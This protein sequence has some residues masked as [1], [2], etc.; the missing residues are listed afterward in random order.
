[1]IRS[2]L[3]DAVKDRLAIR[4]DGSG[5]SLDGLI[6]NTYVNTSINDA[7]NRLSIERDWWWLATTAS[8]TFSTTTGKASL[9]ADFLR[10]NELV[11]NG[12]PAQLLP[13]DT[14]IDPLSDNATYGWLIYGNQIQL[15][16]VPSV[17]PTATLYYFRSEP[18]LTTDAATPI[19]PPAYHYA[20]VSYASYLCAARRQDEPRASLYLQE[21]GSF[22]KTMAN[23]NKTTIK[24][25]IKFSRRRDYATW[26]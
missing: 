7:L 25:Q 19:L 13:L 12:S 14:V 9:P 18:A 1:M 3:R 2:E 8:P 21:Y 6:T 10:A 17:A 11:V 22:L 24:K 15:T 26:L 16:P 20:V 5:N 23:D 4:S